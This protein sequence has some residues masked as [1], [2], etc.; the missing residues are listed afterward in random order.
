MSNAPKTT[1]NVRI[2]RAI[3]QD[4]LDIALSVIADRGDEN[5]EYSRLFGVAQ[6]AIK[7]YIDNFA[8]TSP[9]TA[10]ANSAESG[11][12]AWYPV[13]AITV[14][15]DKGNRYAKAIVGKWKKHG[16]TL[17]PEVLEQIG[18][19]PEDIPDSGID[20]IT[21]VYALV[22]EKDGK[23]KIAALKRD[24]GAKAGSHGG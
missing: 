4:E 17:W 13:E 6:Q 19:K 12:G 20:N 18:R 23:P 1:I 10:G 2:K 24:N 15:V 3:G 22:V 14:T 11:N 16:L 5:Y 7:D 21:G 9:I 8:P